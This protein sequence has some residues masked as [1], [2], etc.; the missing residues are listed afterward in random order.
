M[1]LS[2]I[3]CSDIWRSSASRLPRV[4]SAS[5]SHHDFGPWNLV[6]SQGLPIG[7]IDFDE[8]A[9]GARAEDLGYALWKHLNLGLVE[10]DPAEQRRRLCLMAAAY[11]ALADT[12]LLDAIAVAQRRME[13]KIQEAPSGKRRSGALAQNGREQEWLRGN[14]GLLAS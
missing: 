6:W 10:L 3:A 2:F 9:P 13:R 5:R 1:R 14:A 4:S 11:G 8:A 12:E 7:I